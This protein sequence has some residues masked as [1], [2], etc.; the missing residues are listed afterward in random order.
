MTSV[1][2]TEIQTKRQPWGVTG[3]TIVM[4]VFLVGFVAFPLRTVGANLDYLPGDPADNRL[5][6][7][8]LEH[9]YRYLTRRVDSFWDAPMFYPTLKA[10]TRSDAHL[11]MLPIYA[12][13]RIVGYSPE[14]AFQGWFLIPFILN[15]ATSAWAIRRFGFGPIAVAAGAYTFTFPISVAAQTLHA[16]L[17]PRFLVAPA[18]VFAWEFLRTPRTW[19]LGAVAACWVGQTY[20]TVYMGY[21]LVLLLLVGFVITLARF[22]RQL[23]W[24]ELLLPGWRVW[25]GRVAV[26]AATG[27]AIFP[28]MWAHGRGVGTLSKEHFLVFAPRPGAWLTPPV[29]AGTY[30]ELAD[31]TGLGTW[32][33]AEQQLCPGFTS[34]LAVGLG[35][36]V[37]FRPNTVDDRWSVVAVAAWSA[38]LLALLVTR[39]GTWWPYESLIGLPGAGGIRAVGRVVFVIMFPAAVVVGAFAERIV[40]ATASMGRGV[41][42]IVAFLA[43]LAVMAD[44]WLVSTTGSTAGKWKAMRYS[45]ETAV[46]RQNKVAEVIRRHPAPTAV[47]VFPSATPSG[48]L[49]VQLEAM[50]ATQDLGLPCVNGW[51]GY[52]PQGWDYVTFFPS[53][54]SL[55]NWLTSTNNL[56][57]E[58]LTGLVVVGEPQADADP[59]YEAAMRA[60]HPP[61]IVP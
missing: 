21:F 22:G 34:I 19:R 49:G 44:H 43:F 1:S 30:P 28:L 29:H 32:E 40:H 60:A 8:I 38:I 53:Y 52:S 57:S 61:Q 9:G 41:T 2:K 20:L 4:A 3:W 24:R 46:T 12:A 10:T 59:A 14:C 33:V 47:H 17:F 54:R 35:L 58:Q 6:N 48:G 18:V 13:L 15:F 26:I 39:Y 23:P 50:R 51:S 55:I 11:G 56:T 42:V 36:I 16:Q 45:R 27:I 37:L 31:I 5:N 7:Y 25:F